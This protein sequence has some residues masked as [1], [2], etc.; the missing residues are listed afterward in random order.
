[1]KNYAI[2]FQKRGLVIVNADTGKKE[3]VIKYPELG[4]EISLPIRYTISSADDRLLGN[5][6]SFIPERNR[7]EMKN[8]N[9]QSAL[10][11][12]GNESSYLGPNREDTM[13]GSLIW[14]I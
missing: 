12:D 7:I 6:N 8:G 13:L 4:E 14:K 3:A 10:I 2:D 1:M 11:I 9:K 5:V